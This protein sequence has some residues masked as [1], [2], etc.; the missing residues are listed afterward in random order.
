MRRVLHPLDRA[1]PV[2]VAGESAF[3]ARSDFWAIG[4]DQ[5]SFRT[6]SGA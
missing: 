4:R 2:G 6:S 5:F 1:R 3:F